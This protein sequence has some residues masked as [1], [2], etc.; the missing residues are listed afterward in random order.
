[1]PFYKDPYSHG[2][3][4]FDFKVVFPPNGSLKTDQEEVLRKAFNYS[5]RNAG[6]DKKENTLVL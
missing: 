5:S 4:Y 3:M 1:M 2:N 6:L